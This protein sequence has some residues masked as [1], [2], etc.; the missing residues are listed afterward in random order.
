MLSDRWRPGVRRARR[1]SQRARNGPPGLEPRELAAENRR[2]AVP[3]PSSLAGGPGRR[4]AV[5]KTKIPRIAAGLDAVSCSAR[6]L[7][8]PFP[9]WLWHLAGVMQV[10]G[11]SAGQNP[12]ASLDRNQSSTGVKRKRPVIPSAAK[13]LRGSHRRL[14]GLES[15]IGVVTRNGTHACQPR[16]FEFGI[17]RCA[18]DDRQMA[19]SRGLAG[20]SPVPGRRGP[21]SP[22]PGN[23]LA[24]VRAI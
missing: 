21:T 16:R 12:R 22:V 11:R 1:R 24:K 23:C 15:S 19:D 8:F 9:G 17:P 7:S 6:A 20:A 4:T 5:P 2:A 14:P 3:F 13:D 10:A 18:R